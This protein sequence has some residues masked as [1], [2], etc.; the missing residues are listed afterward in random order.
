MDTRVTR[1]SV[2]AL[3]EEERFWALMAPAWDGPER[4]T[5]GQRVLACVTYFV[6]DVD[7]GGLEQAIFN[8]DAGELAEVHR[9][10]AALG[11]DRLAQLLQSAEQALLGSRPPA[12]LEERRVAID[13]HPGEW[14]DERIEPLNE[15]FYGEEQLYPHFRQYI[16]R[17]PDEFFRD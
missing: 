12:S 7:N 4:G 5:R 10:L 13:E 14:L 16:A 17:N 2:Q 6:R 15:Q 1:D 11:A 3:S 8:R 9:A